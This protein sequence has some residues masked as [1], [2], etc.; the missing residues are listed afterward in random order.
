[1]KEAPERRRG[2]RLE[3]STDAQRHN[4]LVFLMC[5][6]LHFYLRAHGAAAGLKCCYT[7]MQ[8][9]KP[10]QDC[11]RSSS[12]EIKS[13]GICSSFSRSWDVKRFNKEPWDW[14]NCVCYFL[15]GWNK[16]LQPHGSLWKRFESPGLD[17]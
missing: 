11:S 6:F 14:S 15:I 5:F 16:D 4:F 1:M 7:I 3:I 13:Y 8:T 9:S 2:H 17:Y 10:T 12:E